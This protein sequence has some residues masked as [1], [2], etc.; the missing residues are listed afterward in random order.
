[1]FQSPAYDNF[2]KLLGYPGQHAWF[3]RRGAVLIAEHDD[4]GHAD[5]V[6]RMHT[7]M[8]SPLMAVS[9]VSVMLDC[10]FE[11][12]HTDKMIGSRFWLRRLPC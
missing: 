8:L 1:M 2:Y 3:E 11:S 7:L 5:A 12:E 10:R 4:D 9:T 6:S